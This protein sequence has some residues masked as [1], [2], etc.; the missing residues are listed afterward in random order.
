MDVPSQ[1]ALDMYSAARLH[2]ALHEAPPHPAE[3]HRLYELEDE[4]TRWQ[5]RPLQAEVASPAIP[6]G[7]RARTLQAQTT[8]HK[9][10]R[11]SDLYACAVAPSPAP[12]PP[13]HTQALTVHASP[14]RMSPTAMVERFLPEVEERLAAPPP[15]PL[16]PRWLIGMPAAAAPAP[17]GGAAPYSHQYRGQ[18]AVMMPEPL[19]PPLR[20]E[21]RHQLLLLRNAA[22]AAELPAARVRRPML[23]SSQS[24]PQLGLHGGMGAGPPFAAAPLGPPRDSL[25]VMDRVPEAKKAAHEPHMEPHGL[26]WAGNAVRSAVAMARPMVPPDPRRHLRSHPFLIG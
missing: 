15:P 8:N 18:P 4:D 6:A 17:A 20:H 9:R 23:G 2:R 22:A 14:C 7:G 12:T 26:L 3:P 21:L 24:E 10:R 16:Q 25:A 19:V 11:C 13:P 5:R 1:A